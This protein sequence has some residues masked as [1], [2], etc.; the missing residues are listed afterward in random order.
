MSDDSAK[1][2][3]SPSY[4]SMP[5]GD[6]IEAV[7]MIETK[8][9]SSSIDREAAA[10]LV[11][12]SSL[13]GPASKALADLAS[14][15]LVE[16]SGKGEL[17]VTDRARAILHPES[18][19]ER[20]RNLKAAAK[21]PELFQELFE[22]FPE[23]HEEGIAIYLNRQNFNSN[24]VKPATKAY[25]QTLNYLHGFGASESHTPESSPN[26]E[27]SVSGWNAVAYGGANVGDFIQW[28][29]NGA[30]KFETPPRVRKVSVDGQWIAVEGIERGIPMNEVTVEA[31]AP[32]T[33]PSFPLDEET[34]RKEGE[35]EWMRNRV[36]LETNVRLLVKGNMGPKEIGR[37]IKLLEAQKA[38]LEDE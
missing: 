20:R 24:A 31:R 32:Q 4:P 6:A 2:I 14:Y 21:E 33:A 34:G 10:R 11:G 29:S 8:Y 26:A 9:R 25:I 17:R 15:G 28:I 22:R 19:K 30:P 35:I 18:E 1:F 38:V 36:G 16:R 13:S 5:L 37:L 12:Y 27:S 7:R 23:P 3:R